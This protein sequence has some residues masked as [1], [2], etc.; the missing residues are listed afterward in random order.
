MIKLQKRSTD[1]GIIAGNHPAS[2]FKSIFREIHGDT[3]TE[4][5]RTGGLSCIVIYRFD[6]FTHEK[7]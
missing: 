3:T 6:E 5:L 4:V 1:A 7:Y 2:F